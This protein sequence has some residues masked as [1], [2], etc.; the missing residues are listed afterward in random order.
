MNEKYVVTGGSGFI[1][2]HIVDRLIDENKSVIVID[3]NSNKR[4]PIINPRAKYYN[5]DISNSKNIDEISDILENCTGIFHCAALIDVQESILKPI[6]YELNNTLGTLNLLQAAVKANVKRLVYSSSAAVYGDTD[7]KPISELCP[8]NPLSP[9]GSQKYYGEVMCKVFSQLHGIETCCLR[10]FNAFGERQKISGAYANVIGI[11]K[12]QIKSGLPITI[13]G[14]GEQRRDF[15]YVKDLVN[16]NYL[17]MLSEEKFVGEVFN[18]GSGNNFS[19]NQIANFFDVSKTYIPA[20][21]EP[22]ASLA[23]IK[24]ANK[25]LGWF[26]SMDVEEWIKSNK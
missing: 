10:Y 12:F 22:K 18:I 21:K 19:I 24:K 1:G 8:I 5:I 11:F 2:S 25:I 20:V 26:P 14:D 4:K 9:Y 7:E 13:T 23:N 16:A 15:I 6:I 17:S 3:N